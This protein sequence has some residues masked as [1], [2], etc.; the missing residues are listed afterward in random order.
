[1]KEIKQYQCEFCKNVYSTKGEAVA[2]EAS[3]N[4]ALS[5]KDAFYSRDRK[6]NN[7][8]EALIIVMS[9]GAKVQYDRHEFRL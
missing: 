2:C 6:R 8:P 3:H 4:V 5:I 1:M 7:I 9:N